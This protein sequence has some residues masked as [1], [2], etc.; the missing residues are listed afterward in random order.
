MIDK[1]HRR[2]T[3]THTG[4]KQHESCLLTIIFD[5]MF[6]LCIK[7]LLEYCVVSLVNVKHGYC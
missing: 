5:P 6:V 7:C 4:L 2:I 3:E 1:F